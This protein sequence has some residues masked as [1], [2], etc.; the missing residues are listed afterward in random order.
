M[1]IICTSKNVVDF[2]YESVMNKVLRSKNKE[3]T[4]ITDY[5][6]D[7]TEE[8]R[9]IENIFKAN[10]LE[11][12]SKGLQKGLTQYVGDNY[13][14]E[15]EQIDRQAQME[16]KLGVKDF[17]TDMNRDIY[18]LDMQDEEM[19]D[20]EIEREEYDIGDFLGDGDYRDDDLDDD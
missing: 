20:E 18:K 1:N 2:T 17:V 9:E 10:R 14:E 11:R 15:R 5:L 16:R 7:L 12:W 3:K 19:R 6:K 4:I 8:E 13:D